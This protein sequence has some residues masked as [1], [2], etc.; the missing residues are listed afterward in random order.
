MVVET[1]QVLIDFITL[2]RQFAAVEGVDPPL[3]VV[4]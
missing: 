4:Q 1:G 2:S 3:T